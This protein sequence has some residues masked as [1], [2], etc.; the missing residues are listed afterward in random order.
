MVL[1]KSGGGNN[2]RNM[3][4]ASA[5][6]E[7]IAF[8]DDDDEWMSNKLERQMEVA[9]GN[10]IVAC[11]FI[12]RTSKGSAV[13]PRRL[14]DRDERFADYLFSRRSFLNGEAAVITSTLLI[15]RELIE[16]IPFSVLLRRHQEAD[17]VIR[18]T[19][20]GARIVYAPDP[21]VIFNDDSGRVRVSTSY[22]WKQSLDWVR[23]VR[24]QMS[25]RAYAGFL[26]AS[27][28]A[29]AS[30][31]R[32]WKAFLLILKEAFTLGRPTAR[33]MALYCAMWAMPQG[34][35]QS[36]RSLITPTQRS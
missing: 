8:L 26:L 9:S 12:A 14:P 36:L 15:R 11:R 25:P 5:R 4:A 10:D 20:K 1:A 32:D 19:S 35:R 6:T 22:N 21:L 33:H 3:G 34:A 7:W 13:W 2:A 24:T 29:A 30:D 28:S 16:R 18:T 31:Q 23:S 27:S 17:W